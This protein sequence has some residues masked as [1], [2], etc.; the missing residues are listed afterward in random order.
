[1]SNASNA[2][3]IDVTNI[4]PSTGAGRLSVMVDK[5]IANA[6][7]ALNHQRNREQTRHHIRFLSQEMV[8]GRWRYDGTPIRFDKE[9]RLV[10]GQHRL[11]AIKMLPD[12]QVSIK[13]DVVYG[14][15]ADAIKHIDTGQRPRS[16]ANLLEMHGLKNGKQLS[17]IARHAIFWDP[18]LGYVKSVRKIGAPEFIAF[19]EANPDLNYA[20]AYAME[21]KQLCRIAPMSIPGVFRWLTAKID[22]AASNEFLTTLDEGANLPKGDGRLLLLSV[23][24]NYRAASAKGLARRVTPDHYLAIFIK[25]WNMWRSGRTGAVLAYRPTNERYPLPE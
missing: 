1:M 8:S 19:V 3:F 24:H 12:A 13:F 11:E 10:D 22:E 14:L 9:G 23:L 4:V 16:P 7:L 15:D 17:A 21:L 2:K 6:W 20:C 18:E 25:A 5:R